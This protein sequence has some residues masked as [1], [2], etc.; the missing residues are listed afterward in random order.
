MREFW[1]DRDS[2]FIGANQALALDAGYS[3]P[4]EL[5]G[6]SETDTASAVL[7]DNFRADEQ[8]VMGKKTTKFNFEELK[9]RPDGRQ[10]WLRTSKVPLCNKAGGVI[11]VFG[12][13]GDITGRRI[14]DS[15]LNAG[16]KHYR[17]L[18]ECSFDGLVITDLSGIIITTNQAILDLIEEDN[19]DAVC[20]GSVFR[21][22]ATESLADA[23]RD[24]AGFRLE[25]K[26]VI[27]P[28][29]GSLPEANDLPLR[30]WATTSRTGAG[31]L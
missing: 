23:Q 10:A 9:V 2:V 11:G 26:G 6:K 13:Y 22:I 16:I 31:R 14:M 24:L 5:V 15:K 4:E 1:K 27:E 8:Y 12:T 19:P 30:C 7:A 28:I 25:R 29:P 20:G 18:A 17:Q 21:F 3:D